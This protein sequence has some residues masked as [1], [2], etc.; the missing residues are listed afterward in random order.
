MKYLSKKPAFTLPEVLVSISI[1]VL[2]IFS[3]TSLLV[4]AIRSN[5][6]NVNTLIAYGLAQEG[7]EAARNV[8]DSNWLLGAKF[9]GEVGTQNVK[10]W[11]A[12]FPSFPED[13]TIHYYR[14]ER[15]HPETNLTINPTLSQLSTF[16]PWS[17]EDITV[18]TDFDYGTYAKTR[19][20]KQADESSGFS[21][22]SHS[23]GSEETPFHR[24]VMVTPIAYTSSSNG[25]P[26]N[27]FLKMR[28]TS[29]VQWKESGRDKEV[30]LD[31]ELT[32]WKQDI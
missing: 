2:V 20:Y 9:S 19:L 5:T 18:D 28:V 13:Q 31:T 7:L 6:Q 12:A 21:G 29:V 10:I 23:N 22:Y 15:L 16:A 3:A 17:L 11:G 14:I 25:L 32:D 27:K 4:S 24:F 26:V 8:R 30:R 1:L